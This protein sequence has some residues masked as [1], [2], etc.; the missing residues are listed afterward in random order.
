MSLQLSHKFKA[1]VL[2][3]VNKPLEVMELWDYPL[4]YGQVAVDMIVSGLC[5]AQIQEI[6]GEKGNVKY[7]PHLLGHEGCGIVRSVGAGVSRVKSGDKVVLHWRKAAGIDAAPAIY[8]SKQ[9]TVGAGKVTTLAEMVVVS[10]NRVT[11]VPVDADSELCALLGCGLSTA[12]G[13]IESEADLKMG[14]SILIVGCGGLGANLIRCA[15]LAHAFPIA[16]C[17]VH[18][19]KMKTAMEM[20]ADHFFSS[21]PGVTPSSFDVIVDTSGAPQAL[22]ETIPLLAPS[23]RYLMVGHPKPDAG[24]SIKNADHLFG[25]EG[26]TIKATQ[27]GGFI[28]DRDIPRYIKMWRAGILNAEGIVTH[29]LPLECVNEGFDLVRAG[30]ASRVMIQISNP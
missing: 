5:G 25:G 3:G 14:E 4:E 12:L 19:G 17:D 16:C 27:G 6:R 8:A 26:K 21:S 20:G 9:G 24:V 23:G 10:E 15:K 22:E 2:V 7:M 30:E 1:A 11:P 28:P 29:R 13:T 18:A